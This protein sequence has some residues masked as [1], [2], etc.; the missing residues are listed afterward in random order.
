[1]QPPQDPYL[2]DAVLVAASAAADVDAGAAAAAVDVA[3][4]AGAA[5]DVA[6]VAGAAVDV[7]VVAAAAVAAASAAVFEACSS[8]PASSL[9]SKKHVAL[10]VWG[11]IIKQHTQ[12]SCNQARGQSAT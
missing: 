11:D 3:V 2:P 8:A 4:V 1:M 6:V 10:L 12:P 5:V 9:L 7:A